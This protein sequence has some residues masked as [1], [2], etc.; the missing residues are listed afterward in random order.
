MLAKDP[1]K[2]ESIGMYNIYISIANGE[3]DNNASEGSMRK[4][5]YFL[6]ILMEKENSNVP[7]FPLCLLISIF[8]LTFL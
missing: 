2:E 4:A 6:T 5:I 3:F 7:F 1:M 8:S